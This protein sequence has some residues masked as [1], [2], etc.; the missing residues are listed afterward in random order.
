MVMRAHVYQEIAKMRRTMEESGNSYRDWTQFEEFYLYLAG[1]GLY[2]VGVN[3]F[4]SDSA[5]NFDI[6]LSK[7]CVRQFALVS[8]WCHLQRMNYFSRLSRTRFSFKPCWISDQINFSSS[9][10]WKA[11]STIS[12]SLI[13]NTPEAVNL[14]NQLCAGYGNFC[15]C[16][17]LDRNID[18]FYLIICAIGITTSWIQWHSKINRK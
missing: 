1:I 16:I 17:G 6:D 3:P 2:R 18:V 5:L 7:V 8:V 9:I 13:R 15:S 12:K 11:A 4:L 14:R 10:C